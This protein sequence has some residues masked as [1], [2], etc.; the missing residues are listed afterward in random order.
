MVEPLITI[1]R[2]YIEDNTPPV[3]DVTDPIIERLLNKS[4]QYIHDLQ[5]FAED[6]YF[7]N[8]SRVYKIGYCY[9]MNV[10]LTDGTG[11]VIPTSDYEVDVFNGIITFDSSP[12]ATIPDAVYATFNY[13]NL[14]DAISELWLYRAAKSRFDGTAKLGDE[15]IPEDKGS[16]SYCI[17]KY[18][19]YCQSKNIQMER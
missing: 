14:F 18:W 8:V 5:I 15:G 4:R 12:M 9:L 11:A 10:V 2:D 16:R 13:F 3:Y 19:D 6:Y 7:D 17:R 1:I